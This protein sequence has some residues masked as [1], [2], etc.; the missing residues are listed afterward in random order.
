MYSEV[1]VRVKAGAHHSQQLRSRANE[2]TRTKDLDIVPDLC[3]STLRYWR[4]SNLSQQVS[5]ESTR[6]GMKD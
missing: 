4:L 6:A 5:R 3:T 2:M 1:M